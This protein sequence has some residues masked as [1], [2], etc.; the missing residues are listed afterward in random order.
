ML[1]TLISMAIF[2]FI[3]AD[4]PGPI[5]IIATSTAESFDYRGV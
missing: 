3:G 2:A 5:N 1:S 4:T